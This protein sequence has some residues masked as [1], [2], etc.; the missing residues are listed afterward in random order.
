MRATELVRRWVPELEAAGVETARL[1]AELLIA[2]ALGLDRSRLFLD[3][4][5]LD[6][7][8]WGVAETLLD[9]RAR[10]RA[11]VAQLT[12]ERWFDGVC[13]EVTP[14]VLVPRPETELL[15][16]LA[17]EYAPHGAR[18][19]DVGSGSG[20]IA[21]ALARRRPDLHLTAS[22]VDPAAL[23]VTAR[24]AGRYTGADHDAAT[25]ALQLA[26]LLGEWRGEVVV[27]NPP[28]VEDA[29]REQA[30]PELAH[31]PPHALYAG[32]D[33]LDVIRRLVI[34][35]DAAGAGTVL[36]EHGH[37]QGAAIRALLVQA[38]YAAGTHPDL[39]GHDRVTIGRR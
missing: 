20:A 17:A 34:A 30:Q 6:A 19:I 25:V 33:G 27:S 15:V 29:W 9:R 22:D 16:E 28:Y 12:G 8:Q 11:P 32:A 2:H 23:E 36:I 18:T 10:E 39:T 24:N 1:D 13:L 14:A 37:L 38:G 3:D 21:I 7:G 35:C 26:D 5:E 4:P 31:E